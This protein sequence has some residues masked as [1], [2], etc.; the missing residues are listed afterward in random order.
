[1]EELAPR[2]SR[3]EQRVEIVPGSARVDG[4]SGSASI[5]HV[6]ICLA[7]CIGIRASSDASRQGSRSSRA[8]AERTLSSIPFFSSPIGANRKAS[9]SDPRDRPSQNVSYRPSGCVARADD[10]GRSTRVRLL[11]FIPLAILPGQ[12]P[13]ETRKLPTTA[14]QPTRST[15]LDRNVD[16]RGSDALPRRRLVTVHMSDQS[17]VQRQAR[18]ARMSMLSAERAC[19]R[20]MSAERPP[21]RLHFFSNRPPMRVC[22]SV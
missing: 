21:N 22:A 2:G 8:N 13:R 12:L 3:C 6:N 5:K 9:N 16:H 1:M 17:A 10:T 15:P 7:A 14:Q 4:A 20:P 11:V 18:Q 19:S